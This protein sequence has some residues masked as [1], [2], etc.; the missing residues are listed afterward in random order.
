MTNVMVIILAA[1]VAQ[2]A[3][4]VWFCVRDQCKCC[5]AT[6]TSEPLDDYD[7]GAA[8][9]MENV[10]LNV[11]VTCCGAR[12]M[13]EKEAIVRRKSHTPLPPETSV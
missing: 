1:A 9:G 6:T 11:T 13:V 10:H 8:S 5:C 3:T 4:G 7:N 12:A 2:V